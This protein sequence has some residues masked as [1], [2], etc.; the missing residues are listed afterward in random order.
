MIFE[1]LSKDDLIHFSEIDSINNG[2]I[3]NCI[4]G[5]CSVWRW[6]FEGFL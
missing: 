6:S 5:F 2:L 1:K 4:N 3:N